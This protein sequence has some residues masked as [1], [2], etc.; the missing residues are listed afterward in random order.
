MQ[1]TYPGVSY[2]QINKAISALKTLTKILQGVPPPSSFFWVSLVKSI[3]VPL[4][5]CNNQ[6]FT[7]GFPTKLFLLG[8][9]GQSGI[10][11]NNS[12]EQ[13]DFCKGLPH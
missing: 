11:S 13:Q 1:G 12:R 5:E 10:S 4:T 3:S 7:R 9:L 6:N 8:F 2:L